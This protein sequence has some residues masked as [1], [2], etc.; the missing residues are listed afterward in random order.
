MMKKYLSLLQNKMQAQMKFKMQAQMKFKMQAQMK[1]TSLGKI[2]L[3]N[4]LKYY[5]DIEKMGL[6]IIIKHNS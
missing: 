3:K 5:L 2:S 4:S 6:Q 1:L